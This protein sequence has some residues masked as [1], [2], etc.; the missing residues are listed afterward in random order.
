M[1]NVRGKQ[2][3]EAELLNATWQQNTRWKGVK[4]TYT[5]AEV[6]QLRGRIKI[7]YTLAQ[8]E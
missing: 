2:V 5:A 3:N 6:L 8:T 7:E 1:T 4:R